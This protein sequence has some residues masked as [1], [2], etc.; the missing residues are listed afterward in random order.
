MITEGSS[1][2]H[3]LDHHNHHPNQGEVHVEDEDS[4]EE[5]A[6]EGS[7]EE[8]E[9][10][11]D[12][13]DEDDED[14]VTTVY[15]TEIKYRPLYIAAF[16][17]DWGT[18]LRILRD[19]PGARTAKITEHG[20]TFLHA[21][22]GFCEEK[23][24]LNSI[25]SL[26]DKSDLEATDNDGRTP[27]SYAVSSGNLTALRVL[28]EKRAD[29]QHS[30][31]ISRFGIPAVNYAGAIGL[32]QIALY[33]FSK[34]NFKDDS[35]FSS[36]QA[37]FILS[38]LISSDVIGP[39]LYA[40]KQRDTLALFEFG[41]AFTLLNCL[42]KR[43][44]AF[45]TGTRLGIFERLIYSLISV[46]NKDESFLHDTGSSVKEMVDGH[47]VLFLR[48]NLIK[49]LVQKVKRIRDMKLMHIQALE[50]LDL[51]CNPLDKDEKQYKRCVKIKKAAALTAAKWGNY[52]VLRKILRTCP[53]VV[54]IRAEDGQ[55]LF[56]LAASLRHEKILSLLYE[57][58]P[59]RDR[60]TAFVDNN[61]NK[62][63]HN[64][65]KLPA[66]G[67]L[68]G[69][70]AASQMQREMQWFKAVKS[71]TR[72]N[73]LRWKN[74]DGE[75]ARELFMK[76]HKELL[77]EAESWMR[78][79]A[80]SCTVVAALI[81][82]MVFT[83]SF[84]VPGGDSQDTG[85]PIFLGT[86]AFVVFAMSSAMALFSSITSVLAFTVILTASYL[87]DDFVVSLPLKMIMGLVTLTF[88]A[89]CMMIAFCAT[90]HMVLSQ[91]IKLIVV[92]VSLLAI[93]PILFFI[94]LQLPLLVDMFSTTF[95]NAHLP[96]PD[97]S[98]LRRPLPPPP[99]GVVNWLRELFRRG[100]KAITC[101]GNGR[102]HL[103][104]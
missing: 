36:A 93:I 101:L 19:D 47:E 88:A 5:E 76:E 68:F 23:K 6:E 22:F 9:E 31:H 50:M 98:Y 94:F 61:S 38:T 1:R 57:L 43:P 24:I 11:E 72:P 51:L 63:L 89:A 56:H 73:D 97:N 87:D 41:D 55:T 7:H 45:P 95:G 102:K 20:G 53:S 14:S 21:A 59:Y 91:Q 71:L 35:N 99:L 74:K 26:I 10:E 27:L 75:T 60:V 49:A 12:E 16:T 54:N 62:L 48:R 28:G 79:T 81:A 32:K 40:L 67:R 13:D 17:G 80:Q 34:T 69:F 42:A 66:P 52:E 64:A 85:I 104:N 2:R 83:A 77:K 46:N 86:P 78:D 3:L 18:A 33:L 70:G 90:I 96:S 15:E 8:E 58:G 39:A 92:P 30:L 84:T 4:N 37:Y 100:V 82:T 65:A 44:R 103:A 29:L 25:I